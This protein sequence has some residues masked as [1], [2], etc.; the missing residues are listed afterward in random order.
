VEYFVLSFI[1]L[2]NRT[3]GVFSLKHTQERVW[4]PPLIIVLCHVF[5]RNR[6]VKYIS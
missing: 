3:H 1:M 5:D 4:L 2:Y 6:I